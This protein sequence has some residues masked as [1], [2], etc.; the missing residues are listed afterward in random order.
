MVVSDSEMVI[1]EAQTFISSV[2]VEGHF[3]RIWREAPFRVSWARV[4]RKI[5]E[6]ALLVEVFRWCAPS[7]DS[8]ELS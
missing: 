1:S 3:G 5:S 8:L 7:R 6:A 2:T 4:I